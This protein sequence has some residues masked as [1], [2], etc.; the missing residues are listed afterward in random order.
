MIVPRKSVGERVSCALDGVVTLEKSDQDVDFAVWSRD[1]RCA[2]TKGIFPL[3]CRVS[4]VCS[5]PSDCALLKSGALMYPP[6]RDAWLSALDAPDWDKIRSMFS[7]L[8]RGTKFDSVREHVMEVK[9]RWGI[10]R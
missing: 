7:S 10:A 3:W 1:S 4:S 8:P 2:G 9:R 6:D 5:G